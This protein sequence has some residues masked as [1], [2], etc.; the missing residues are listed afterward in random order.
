[1]VWVNGHRH[2]P[3]AGYQRR[4]VPADPDDELGPVNNFAGHGLT[5]AQTWQAQQRLALAEQRKRLK[6]PWLAA[7]IAGI[8]SAVKRGRV[9]NRAWGVRML[10]RHGGLTMRRHALHHLRAISPA[11]VRASVIARHQRKAAGAFERSWAHEVR[12][13]LPSRPMSFLEF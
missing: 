6:G 5:P 9:G 12:L 10:A 2:I 7:R 3:F 11:G 4:P 13:P 1:M 8:V